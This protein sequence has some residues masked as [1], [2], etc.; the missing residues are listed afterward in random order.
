MDR[1]KWSFKRFWYNWNSNVWT[2]CRFWLT[3]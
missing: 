1:K 2:F 3:S